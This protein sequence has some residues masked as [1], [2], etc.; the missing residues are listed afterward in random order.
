MTR[1]GMARVLGAA[2][3]VWGGVAACLPGGGGLAI[4]VDDGAQE[5]G[6]RSASVG[7]G[8]EG[9]PDCLPGLRCLQRG[10]VRECV[11]VCADD[12]GCAGSSSCL[13]A[14]G[15]EVGWCGDAAGEAV[16][17]DDGEAED[18][19][20]AASDDGGGAASPGGGGGASPG[21]GCGGSEEAAVVS[22]ANTARAQEGLGPLAC[23]AG[24]ERVARGHSEDMAS[25]DYFDHVSPEGETPWD[26]MDRGGIDGYFSAGEN[27][28][29]GYEDAAA[30][31]AGWMGSDGHRANILNGSFTHVGIGIASQGGALVWTQLFAGF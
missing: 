17:W 1:R 22:W 2:W 7:E 28:A 11:E 16:G 15:S 3:L 26:R 13:P 21:G 5:G 24:L 29:W 14:L 4:F 30:V 27:I 25:R 9:S 10:E 8:C 18:D 12:G 19:D 20:E 31:H 23:H 6:A